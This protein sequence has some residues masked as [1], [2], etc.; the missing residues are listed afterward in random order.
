M[1]I[2]LDVYKVAGSDIRRVEY[3]IEK[4]IIW[5]NDCMYAGTNDVDDNYIIAGTV[6]LKHDYAYT[7]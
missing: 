1:H 7:R 5:R 3:E 2:G 4:K 6:Q